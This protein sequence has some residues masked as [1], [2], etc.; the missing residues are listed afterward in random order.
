[1]E[2][3][4][5]DEE[6]KQLK[7]PLEYVLGWLSGRSLSPNILHYEINSCANSVK[8][9]M[10]LSGNV[11]YYELDDLRTMVSDI[12]LM[13]GKLARRI[14]SPNLGEMIQLRYECLSTNKGVYG[15]NLETPAISAFVAHLVKCLNL[16]AIELEFMDP[17]ELATAWPEIPDHTDP[18]DDDFEPPDDVDAETAN[19]MGR[20]FSIENLGKRLA[21]FIEEAKEAE[22]RFAAIADAFENSILP[23]DG[24]MPNATSIKRILSICTTAYY[25]VYSDSDDGEGLALSGFGW[26]DTKE[27]AAQDA[28]KK[29]IERYLDA[30]LKLA[31]R[32]GSS[33]AKEYA[34]MRH[35]F[36]KNKKKFIQS[37]DD[38]AIAGVLDDFTASLVRCHRQLLGDLDASKIAPDKAV[39]VTLDERSGKVIESAVHAK[40]AE[41]DYFSDA[42]LRILF[43]CGVNTP[44]NWR[45]GKSP[46]E[47]FT[48]AFLKRDYTAMQLCAER[49]KANRA[50]SDAMNSRRLVRNMSE[51][52]M[53]RESL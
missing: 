50:K 33:T 9:L 34:S 51:E 43:E 20:D 41:K 7:Q 37:T 2:R 27:A 39:A 29:A 47:G 45:R 24:D 1:M 42:N 17:A 32:L 21:G 25:N 6:L 11:P 52:Q 49:Y 48:D 22:N 38:M 4:M 3:D 26:E 10:S 13:M 44:A 36:I 35:T 16:L 18:D 12:T 53:N 15:L 46:P 30:A 8:T 5:T 23:D 40:P 19:A 14:S 31:K 28:A